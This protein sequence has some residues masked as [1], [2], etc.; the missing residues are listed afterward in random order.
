VSAIS[1]CLSELKLTKAQNSGNTSFLSLKGK[2]RKQIQL[3]DLAKAVLTDKCV[4]V[5]NIKSRKEIIN[6]YSKFLP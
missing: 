5:N 3:W 1:H 4:V 2:E 6:Q